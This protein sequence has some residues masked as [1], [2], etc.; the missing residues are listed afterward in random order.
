MPEPMKT[1]ISSRFP[2]E[3]ETGIHQGLLAG[4]HGKLR[5]A[6]G[7]PHLFGRGERRGGIKVPNLGGNRAS[8]AGVEGGDPVNPAST[9]DQIVPKGVDF[10]AQGRDY[11]QPGDHHSTI[12][13]IGRHG[14]KERGRLEP[15]A[16]DGPPAREIDP[17][18]SVVSSMHLTTSPTLCSFSASS[19]GISWPNSSS[20]AITSSTVSRESAPKSSINLASGVT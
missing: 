6:I 4:I 8:K 13:R 17:I 18:T 16:E 1:P 12:H 3:V 20:R 5:E 9:R 7:A 14:N 2:V 15:K 11:A 19:S 10:L